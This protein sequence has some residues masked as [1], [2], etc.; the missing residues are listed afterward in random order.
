MAAGSFGI[1]IPVS[2]FR[3]NLTPAGAILARVPVLPPGRDRL[4]PMCL[5]RM[6]DNGLGWTRSS[7]RGREADS[8]RHEQTGDAR[9]SHSTVIVRRR[10]RICGGA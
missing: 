5:A 8:V 4:S 1:V 6:S 10:A 7:A 2:R 9:A 3:T